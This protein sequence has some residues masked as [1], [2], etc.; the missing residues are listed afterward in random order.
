[1]S[2]DPRTVV[3]Y[4]VAAA[5][6]RPGDLVNTNPGDQDWQEVVGVYTSSEGASDPDIQALAGELDGRYVIVQLTDISPVDSGIFFDGGTAMVYGTDD[7]SD[8][9]VSGVVSTEDGTRTYLYTKFELVTVRS[10][11]GLV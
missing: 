9:P 4:R 2:S 6:L 1:M 8:S 7:D 10:T 5:D 11:Q 3:E